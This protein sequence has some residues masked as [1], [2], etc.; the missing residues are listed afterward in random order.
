[1]S[2][3]TM[4]GLDAD[5]LRSWGEGGLPGSS[6]KRA[7]MSGRAGQRP[8]GSGRTCQLGATQHAASPEGPGVRVRLGREES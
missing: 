5:A 6:E 4:R 8:E 7:L 3:N 1:M 2:W